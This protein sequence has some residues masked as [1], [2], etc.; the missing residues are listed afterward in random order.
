M[1]YHV[2][3]KQHTTPTPDVELKFQMHAMTKMMERMNF[4]MGNMS[5]RLEKVGKHG[6]VA[7]T[8]PKM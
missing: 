1:Y 5:D 6:N 4:M 3:S 7:G 8:L 2:R